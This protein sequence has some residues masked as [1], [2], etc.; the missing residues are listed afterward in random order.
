M[1]AAVDAPANPGGGGRAGRGTVA[2]PGAR[3]QHVLTECVVPALKKRLG[4]V[5]DLLNDP[6]V[7]ACFAESV[8]A[9]RGVFKRFSSLDQTSAPPLYSTAAVAHSDK[10]NV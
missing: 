2:R 8:Y 5:H 6:A 3:L 10:P 9:L 1:Q 7:V 4:P